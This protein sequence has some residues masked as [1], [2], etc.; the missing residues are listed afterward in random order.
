MPCIPSPSSHTLVQNLIL[1]ACF[2]EQ[3]YLECF[4]ANISGYAAFSFLVSEAKEKEKRPIRKRLKYI[5]NKLLFSFYL[6]GHHFMI[7]FFNILLLIPLKYSYYPFCPWSFFFFF[8]FSEQVHSKLVQVSQSFLPGEFQN[9][10]AWQ[11]MVHGVTMSQT[12]LSD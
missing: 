3:K 2:R 6:F 1:W 11:V 7:Y 8:L 9:R 4:V 10:A 12:Q 5:L